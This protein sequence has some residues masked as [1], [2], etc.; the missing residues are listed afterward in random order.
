MSQQIN[1]FNPIFLKQKKIF[2]ALPMAKA[3]GALLLG[4][5]AVGGFGAWRLGALERE[6]A[7]G[8]AQLARRAAR[9][10]QVDKEFLP[11]RP[12]ADI[13]ADVARYE[14]ELATLQDVA[15]VLRQGELGNTQGYAEYFRA[16]AR[17]SVPGVWLTGLT[18]V[19]AGR[20]LGLQ[21]KALQAP[22]I[23]DYIARLKGEVV[24]RGKTF[25]SLTIG[26]AD[27]APD[28]GKAPTPPTAATVSATQTAPTATPP[29]ARPF[30]EFNLQ[31]TGLVTDAGAQ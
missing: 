19:G 8:K 10:A 13:A 28:A 23:P 17:Q 24:M 12:S 1:L 20:E 14:G 30:V 2:A 5:L 4:A 15:R 25:G 31:S 7:A 27:A 29:P 21:G 3:L 18:I 11:R 16:L 26:R 9:L 22:L 6:A